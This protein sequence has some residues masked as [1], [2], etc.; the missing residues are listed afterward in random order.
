MDIGAVPVPAASGA[1]VAANAGMVA[2]IA[3]AMGVRVTVETVIGSLGTM[4]AINIVG[5]ALFVEAARA[6]GWFAGPLGVPGVCALGAFTAGLQTWVVGRLT[7]AICEGGGHELSASEARAVISAAR[8][9]FSGV[10]PNARKA[11]KQRPR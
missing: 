6:M 5:R 2:T 3:S 10:I 7:V 8:S 9:S 4:G 11:A 1:I